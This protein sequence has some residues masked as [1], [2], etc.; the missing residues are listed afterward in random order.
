MYL[1]ILVTVFDSFVL[2]FLAETHQGTFQILHFFMTA[3][4][5]LSESL[6]KTQFLAFTMLICIELVLNYPTVLI[7]TF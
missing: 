6:L 2:L 3:N 5:I 4:L 1:L 7:S